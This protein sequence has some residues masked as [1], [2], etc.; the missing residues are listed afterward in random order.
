MTEFEAILVVD[1]DA[2]VMGDLTH[3]FNLPTDFAWALESGER[4]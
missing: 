3:L 1:T 4:S 2:I